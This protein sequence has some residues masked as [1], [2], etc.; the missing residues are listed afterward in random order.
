MVV[1]MDFDRSTY[2]R[3]QMVIK[4]IPS[5]GVP[6][7]FNPTAQSSDCRFRDEFQNFVISARALWWVQGNAEFCEKSEYVLFVLN[8]RDCE[9]QLLNL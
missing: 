8:G 6:F 2:Q 7:H 1:V 5:A 9:L 3:W 4:N